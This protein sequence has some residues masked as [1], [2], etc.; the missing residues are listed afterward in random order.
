MRAHPPHRLSLL[1]ETG[2]AGA[3]SAVPRERKRERRREEGRER[4][5]EKM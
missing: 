5:G 1:K 3:T 2:A 4:K